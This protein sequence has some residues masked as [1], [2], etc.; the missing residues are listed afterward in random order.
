MPAEPK[1]RDP[2]A[3]AQLVIEVKDLQGNVWGTLT[4][5]GKHFSS[6]SIGFYAN[7]KVENPT[8]HERYQVGANITLI[9]S[10]PDSK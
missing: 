3:P 4:A 5:T 1:K 10:K 6:G 9:G 2:E 7:G 8:S